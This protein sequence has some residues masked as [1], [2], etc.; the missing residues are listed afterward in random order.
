[1]NQNP[2]LLMQIIPFVAVAAIFYFLLI[3]PQQ[4][5]MKETKKMLDALKP[6]D[7]VLTVGGMLGVI[8]AVKADEVEL[9]ISKG[10][11]ASFTLSAVRAVVPA[12]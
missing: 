9:E 10:V 8:T 7:K 3:R 6:G 11:K 5:Q 4:K 12:K 1:M 2:G